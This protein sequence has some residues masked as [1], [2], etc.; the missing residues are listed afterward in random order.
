MCVCARVCVCVCVCVCWGSGPHLNAPVRVIVKQIQQRKWALG[1]LGLGAQ[2]MHVKPKWRLHVLRL[3]K[4]KPFN[5][6]CFVRSH[7]HGSI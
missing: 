1:P 3:H 6:P 5:L 7:C 2:L 4:T